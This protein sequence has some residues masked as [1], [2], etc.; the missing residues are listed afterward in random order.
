[1]SSAA[2]FLS[3]ACSDW[4]VEGQRQGEGGEK[5]INITITPG[6]QKILSE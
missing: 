6:L 3:Q 2:L 4:V 1:M 5:G